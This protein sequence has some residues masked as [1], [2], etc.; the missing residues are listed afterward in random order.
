MAIFI[1]NKTSRLEPKS[2][3]RVESALHH[4]CEGV[5]PWFPTCSS[6]SWHSLPCWG[7]ACCS[8][9]HGQVIGLPQA[10]RHLNQRYHRESAAASPSPL[11]VSPTRPTATPVSRPAL[12]DHRHLLPRHRVW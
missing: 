7:C 12:P 6:T 3:K 4:L 11:P 10:R 5:L 1:L 2:Q 9:A 8:I